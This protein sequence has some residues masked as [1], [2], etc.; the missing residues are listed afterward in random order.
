MLVNKP[1]TRVGIFTLAALAAMIGLF[2]WLSGS[3]LLQRG[4]RVEAEFRRIEGL[5]PGAPVKFTGV[6][7]G[8][9]SEI[10]FDNMKVVVVMRI[11][12]EFK[13]DHSAKA[14]IA[15]N[16]VVGDKFVELAPLGPGEKP[17]KNDRIP[18]MEPVSMDQLYYSVYDVIASIQEI[19]ES[20][21]SLTGDPE[22]ARSLKNSLRNIERL[23]SNVQKLTAQF[24]EIDLPTFF[25]RIDNI[26]AVAERLTQNNETQLNEFVQNINTASVQLLQ[27]SL[28]ANQ[29]LQ[30]ADAGGQLGDD[31]RQTMASAQKT[32]ANLEKFSTLLATKEKE[33]DQLLA[34]A[35][36]TLTAITEAA[37]SV[38]RA[39]NQ[40]TS[41]EGSLSTVQETITQVNQMTAQ[42]NEYIDKINQI[43]V[44]NSAGAGYLKDSGLSVDYRMDLTLNPKNGLI[45]GVADI[46]AENLGTLQYAR[47]GP[48]FTGRAGLYKNEFGVGLDYSAT[49]NWS[50]G[51]DVWDTQ[52]A[53]AGLSTSVRLGGDWRLGLS[54]STSLEEDDEESWDCKLWK[55]F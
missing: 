25:G 51:V 9:V 34:D 55:Q 32:A 19:A 43:S 18:G 45:L 36:Q 5:R 14:V 39:V 47:T 41:G 24:D 30:Q 7:V 31:L 50:L 33:V 1:E 2:L 49:P 4:Y 54:G 35:H 52:S 22:V 44:K 29:F 12:P 40:L 42:V 17:L 6:D 20:I 28:T 3:Q 8:R 21:K 26:V 16:G 10:Y 27:A 38:N 11:R 46:G 37:Q 53:K 23:S 15:S 48:N 13:L